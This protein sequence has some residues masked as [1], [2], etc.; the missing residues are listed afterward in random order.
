MSGKKK[1]LKLYETRAVFENTDTGNCLVATQLKDGIRDITTCDTSQLPDV[2]PPLQVIPIEAIYGLYDLLTGP[3]VAVVL[4]SEPFISKEPKWIRKVKKIIMLPL[5]TNTRQLSSRKQNDE[6]R[7]LY[8]LD[9]AFSEHTFFFS[10]SYD[11]TQTQQKIAKIAQSN[12]ASAP[13]WTR[14]D[15]RFFWNKECV[16]DLIACDADEWI[17]PFMSAYIEYIPD[18]E[19]DDDKFATLFITRRSRFR[20][21]C[22]FTKRGIDDDGNVANFAETEQI[23]LFPDGRISS[24]VQIRGSIPITWKSPVHM[25]YA[26]VV[27]IADNKMKNVELC[28]KHIVEILREYTGE[29][30]KTG[31]IFVNLID[32][33][34]EQGR[35][36]RVFK[37]VV[38]SVQAKIQQQILKYI[39]FDFHAECKQKGKWNNL[40]L[41]INQVDQSFRAQGFF[42]KDA[43]GHVITQQS[44]VLRTNCMDN[45]DRT[46][47]VQSLFARRS[48]LIQLG[49]DYLLTDDKNVLNSPFKPFEKIY[50]SIWA[51]NAN[52]IS[53]LYAGTGALKVDFT[54][55]GKRTIKGMIDDGIN[56][57]MRYYINNFTDG[58][59]QDSI[60]LLLGNYRPDITL[61][62]PF[63]TR[64][65]QETLASNG[66]KAFVMMMLIFSVLLLL[67]PRH[68]VE[69]QEENYLSFHLLLSFAITSIVVMYMFYLVV[70]K[71]SR[72]GD[73]LV[74][75]P[76]LL[77]AS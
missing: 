7:Y 55:T 3:Y 76:Q 75:I 62:S 5:F 4:E 31:I 17:I 9:K 71:G 34:K 39:W 70:R 47:V 23:L 61:P 65:G 20:A 15:N 63:V 14:A 44:G 10:S 72:L 53:M 22:R 64:V 48:L 46:N 32:G 74:V 52:A 56:S 45:L 2:E 33:K 11:L 51:N 18:C 40:A 12:A 37:E 68:L 60:D 21:G 26:P 69:G 28:E 66:T 57:C 13:I 6:D 30:G 73:K 25:K 16:R 8:L 38:D 67:S 54:K 24:Y 77:P 35:L 49:K 36:G 59:K 50:K 41:L 42:S 43:T 29:H 58:M 19:I 1:L 27:S